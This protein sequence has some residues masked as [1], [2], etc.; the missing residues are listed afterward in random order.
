[1]VLIALKQ[2][3][4]RCRTGVPGFDEI[5]QGGFIRGSLILLAGAPGTGK[6]T[7]SARFLYEGARRW[8]E[9]GIYVSFAETKS[10][11]YAY[12]QNFNMEF[13]KLEKENMFKFLQIPT[14]ISREAISSFLELL[15]NNVI[16]MNVKRL[17]IDSITPITQVLGPIESR[18]TLHNA[19]Y[20]IANLYNV[21]IIMIQDLPIGRGK[22]GYG[23]E[24]FIADTVI[25]L[26]LDYTK[27]GAYRR[28]MNILKFRGTW[29]S[30][31][32]I[33]Y[34]I[35]PGIGFVLHPPITMKNIFVDRSNRIKTYIN[36]LDRI[37]GG[38]FIKST[39]TLI[40]GPSGSG[41]TLLTLIIAAETAL[42]GSKVIYVSFDEPAS[43]LKESLRMLGYP[44]KN[45]EDKLK[46]VSISSQDIS[47]GKLRWILSNLIYS[48]TELIELVIIDGVTALL[49]IFDKREF[50]RTIEETIRCLKN[51][52]ITAI[53]NLTSSQLLKGEDYIDSLI[54][55]LADNILLLNTY[56]ENNKLYRKIMVLKSRMNLIES[57]WY[58]IEV[59]KDRKIELKE[60]K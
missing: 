58:K 20:N 51:E 43:Q 30:D 3:I 47:P 17:V 26:N 7:F 28:Y 1:M 15:F 37:L 13:E 10:K 49:H 12:M 6:S 45:I 19:L 56:F 16:S 5:T 48:D 9:P 34:S 36:D 29:I 44:Y 55:I 14:T 54:H 32:A 33:E 59:S 42:H 38:G 60:L 21:T 11:F 35:V 39:S 46:I 50:I 57:K 2:E 22:I 8:R 23:V 4:E 24:E 41:K 31:I 40:I 25:M 27:P 52:N 53:L 18:A